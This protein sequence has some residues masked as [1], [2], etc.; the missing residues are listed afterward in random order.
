[1]SDAV[2]LMFIYSNKI[3]IL[4]FAGSCFRVFLE[5]GN[6]DTYD[7]QYYFISI[8]IPTH[9]YAYRYIIHTYGLLT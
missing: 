5:Y 9:T 3:G 6:I 4:V 2:L 1:M 8:F 7:A